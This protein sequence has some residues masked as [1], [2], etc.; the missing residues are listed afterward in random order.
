MFAFFAMLAGLPPHW[1]ICRQSHTWHGQM[2]WSGAADA[3]QTLGNLT[4]QSKLALVS[5]HMPRPPTLWRQPRQQPRGP[6]VL[7]I[8]IA[9]CSDL[10]LSCLGFAWLGARA[11]VSNPHATENA[12]ALFNKKTQAEREEKSFSSGSEKKKKNN[13]NKKEKVVP[14]ISCCSDFSLLEMKIRFRF[15]FGGGRLYSLYIQLLG[16]GSGSLTENKK[17]RRWSYIIQAVRGAAEA[18][19]R[20]WEGEE[21]AGEK[22]RARR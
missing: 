7:I 19:W 17:T 1:L 3:N 4:E 8:C 2:P 11:G 10:W 6:W 20:G 21:G 14:R 16:F 9:S 22:E 13:N 18:S 12:A 5:L 15:L